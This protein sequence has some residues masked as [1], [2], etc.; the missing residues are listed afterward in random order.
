MRKTLNLAKILKLGKP[1]VIFDLETTGPMISADRIVEIA[2]IKIFPNG[3]EVRGD[4]FLNPEREVSDESVQVHG[5]TDDMSTDKPTF[6]EKA[7]ELW[8]VF[9]GAYYA[10]FNI[11]NFDLPVLRREFIRAGMD[12]TYTT[13]QIIDTKIIMQFME[14]RTL[15]YAVKYYC[16]NTSLKLQNASADAQAAFL[17]LGKQLKKYNGAMADIAF[18]NKIHKAKDVES[19]LYTNLTNKFYWKNGKAHFGFSEYKDRPLE[20]VA[21]KD[22]EFMNWILKADFSED[23]KYLV[24]KTLQKTKKKNLKKNK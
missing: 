21:V 22:R 8:D 5:I 16:R 7:Q 13:E 9:S 18:I 17:I 19:R 6:R 4:L 3:R 11:N 12:F 20:E 15:S 2:F 1:L 14:P 10:G 23:L 24:E